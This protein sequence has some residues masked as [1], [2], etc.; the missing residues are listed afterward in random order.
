MNKL[1]GRFVMY[2]PVNKM[3]IAVLHPCFIVSCYFGVNEG[4]CKN[5]AS[6]YLAFYSFQMLFSLPGL[7][8]LCN[9]FQGKYA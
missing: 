5:H 8:N 1:G 7:T 2:G 6:S 4:M 3:W 9:N